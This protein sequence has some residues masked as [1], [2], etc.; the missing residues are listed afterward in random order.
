MIKDGN[1]AKI[2]DGN[3]ADK[4]KKPANQG[5]IDYGSPEDFYK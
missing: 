4:T 3:Y 1:M 5:D 2:L